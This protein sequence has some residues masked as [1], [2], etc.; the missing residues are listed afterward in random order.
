MSHIRDRFEELEKGK[1]DY[2]HDDLYLLSED[3]VSAI[4]HIDNPEVIRVERTYRG[5][6]RWVSQCYTFESVFGENLNKILHQ[7]IS[8]KASHDEDVVFSLE[9][10]REEMRDRIFEY[11]YFN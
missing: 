8:G 1:G 3:L 4:L 5:R 10:F 9:E 7:A 2:G 6:G 11:L